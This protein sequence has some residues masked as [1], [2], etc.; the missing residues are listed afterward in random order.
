M[1]NGL[2]LRLD[3][4]PFKSQLTWP[5]LL[6]ARP[7]HKE[8]GGSQRFFETSLPLLSEGA[9]LF[10]ICFCSSLW[11]GTVKSFKESWANS[12]GMI[13]NTWW[14]YVIFAILIIYYKRRP[15]SF[16]WDRNIFRRLWSLLLPAVHQGSS[17]DPESRLLKSNRREA[18]KTYQEMWTYWKTSFGLE[19]LHRT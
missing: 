17:L 1:R 18:S 19:Y 3:R 12:V 2:C 13:L 10:A 11:R 5:L 8:F 6:R 7:R 9:R 4:G 16:V 14:T 15:N